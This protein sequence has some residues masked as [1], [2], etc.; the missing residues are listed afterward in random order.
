MCVGELVC[1]KRVI[2][3]QIDN[4]RAVEIL[5]ENGAKPNTHSEYSARSAI[6]LAF[7][8]SKCH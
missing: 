7:D 8:S 6:Q 3:I 2:S 1:S 4:S 5:L